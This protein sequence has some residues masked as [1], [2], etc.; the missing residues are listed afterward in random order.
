[1]RHGSSFTIISRAAATGAIP[2]VSVSLQP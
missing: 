1:V 2:V